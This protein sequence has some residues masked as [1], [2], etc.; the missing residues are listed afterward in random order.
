MLLFKSIKGTFFY[1]PEKEL[2]EYIVKKEDLPKILEHDELGGAELDEIEHVI[3][4]FEHYF[5]QKTC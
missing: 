2:E 1:I 3:N 5:H 4:G